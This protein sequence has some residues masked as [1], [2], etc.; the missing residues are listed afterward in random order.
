MMVWVVARLDQSISHE[1]SE[2]SMRRLEDMRATGE[3][4]G[5][6]REGDEIR[7]LNPAISR[8]VNEAVRNRPIS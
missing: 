4:T 5:V 1:A 8:R 6:R 7:H 2:P 3:A